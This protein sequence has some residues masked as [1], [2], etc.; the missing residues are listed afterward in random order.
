[1]A[2]ISPRKS[3]R[4]QSGGLPQPKNIGIG[5]GTAIGIRI[6]DLDDLSKNPMTDSDCDDDTDSDTEHYTQKL[7]SKHQKLKRLFFKDCSRMDAYQRSIT[8]FRTIRSRAERLFR[9]Y[10]KYS[11]M[12]IFSLGFIWD[13]LTLT[14]VDSI[15]DN[16]VLLLYLII[17]AIM[18]ILTLRHQGGRILPQW[19]QKLQPRFS[20]VMQW[21]FGGLFSSY[22]IF[23]FKSA[24]WTR[25]QFF[26]LILVFLWIGNE[27]LEHR[28]QNPKLLSVLYCFCLFSFLAFFLPVV[29]AKV[30]TRIFVLSGFAS[31]TLSLIVFA[32]GL[33]A[34]NAWKRKMAPIA[35]GIAVTF[36]TVNLL[37]FANLIPP[38]P[39]A[40]KSARIYHQVKR[41]SDGYIV[42][43]VSPPL[44]RF[45]R[46]WD[47]PFYLSP[48]ESAYCY[49]AVFAP[50]NV[51]VP[52]H[53]V[54]S[55]RTAGGWAQTDR[56]KFEIAG[57]REGGYRGYTKKS[58]IVPGKWRV[59][60]KTE[61]GRI[62]G[63]ID[64]T[65]SVS[66]TPHPPLQTSL[67]R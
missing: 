52:V 57:G 9:K 34:E 33:P 50:A 11:G 38:V 41:T 63:R 48:G 4:T 12:A 42:K 7:W 5:I 29:F 20:W 6:C 58:G 28:L 46:K 21:C 18:I 30:N 32:S 3:P 49:T 39:L 17:I 44:L 31:F 67:I 37:Y 35:A 27:F 64:F 56:I 40:L 45:W 14:R 36:L 15:M 66:P 51:H 22:V 54:W 24:S 47:N 2:G 25:T 23:Y 26:F 8:L 19:I 53:H 10:E 1:M 60:V 65:A 59:E 13:S 43:Y 16:L 55:L 62:L 61:E